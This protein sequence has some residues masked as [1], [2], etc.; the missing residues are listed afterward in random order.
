[1]K[2]KIINSIKY[3]AFLAVGLLLLYLAFSGVDL[4]EM[5]TSLKEA[6]YFYVV[7]SMLMGFAAFISRGVRWVILINSLGYKSSKVNCISAVSLGY[8]AN[9]AI[10]RIGEITRCTSLN[11]V[12]DIPVN[13]LFGTI[14]LE[15]AIDMI[16]LLGLVSSAFILQFDKISLFFEEALGAEGGESSNVKFYIL[17]VGVLGLLGLFLLRNLFKKLP[18]YG[19]VLGFLIGLKEGFQSISTMERKWSF[20]L[21][22]VFI[23]VMYFSMTFVCIYALPETSHL[24]MADGIILMV[25][26]GLGMVVPAQGGI[27]S[28]HYA[29]VLG[30]VTLGIPK[31]S[32]VGLTYATMVHAAQTLMILVTGGL[33]VLLL[34]LARRKKARNEAIANT[35]I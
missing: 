15:R 19:K 4:D 18:L 28:Y 31:E 30:M 9:L 16:I 10:P 14:L 8:L 35:R 33:A 7:I 17:G 6:D 1:L 21:H 22:T 29:I 12:E 20:W 34:Y 5:S 23:W 25:A 2:K 3:M 11:Q 24:T 13:K 26:G 32:G 27:G